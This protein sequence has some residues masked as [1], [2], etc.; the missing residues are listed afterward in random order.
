MPGFCGRS[1]RD[2]LAGFTIGAIQRFVELQ[3]GAQIAALRFEGLAHA[4][5]DFIV[6]PY[7]LHRYTHQVWQQGHDASHEGMISESTLFRM[8]FGDQQLQRIGISTP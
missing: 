5:A 6:A 3:H 4:G 2:H 1:A 8:N 7:F